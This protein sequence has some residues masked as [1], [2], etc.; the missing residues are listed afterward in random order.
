MGGKDF[1]YYQK[2]VPGCYV[3]LDSRNEEKGII[4]GLHHPQFMVDE[5]AIK[6]GVKWMA[7]TAFQLLE[8]K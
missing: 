6:I 2:E 5:E 4:H 8:N 3:W 1:S 7:Q